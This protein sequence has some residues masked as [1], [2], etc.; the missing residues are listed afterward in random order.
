M[1]NSS[2]KQRYMTGTVYEN[3]IPATLKEKHEL[4]KIE[5]LRRVLKEELDKEA[6]QKIETILKELKSKIGVF[7]KIPVLKAAYENALS[8]ALSIFAKRSGGR[9]F[10]KAIGDFFTG[11]TPQDKLLKDITN[12]TKNLQ[13]MFSL[14]TRLSGEI[15]GSDA[16]LT[17]KEILQR[18]KA[19]ASPGE[20]EDKDPKASTEKI[21]SEI[22]ALIEGFSS[23]DDS[24][25][26]QIIDKLKLSK[27]T[28][29]QRLTSYQDIVNKSESSDQKEMY[30]KSIDDLNDLKTLIDKNLPEEE[31]ERDS[32]TPDEIRKMIEKSTSSKPIREKYQSLVEP[33]G[34]STIDGLRKNILDLM[35]KRSETADT[36]EK[37]SITG[38]I[39][40]LMSDFSKKL[41]SLSPDERKIEG[42]KIKEDSLRE[43]NDSISKVEAL[44]SDLNG[45]EFIK[46]LLKIPGISQKGKN[47]VLTFA[48]KVS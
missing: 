46:E 26:K 17:V 3:W 13:E 11:G 45:D 30:Q 47:I 9:G 12:F 8:E 23:A 16:S 1:A 14:V 37:R 28:I 41:E 7:D 15:S 34:D 18:S 10:F 44:D 24:K 21:K 5:D 39:S 6:V 32:Y 25:K 20:S 33:K 4:K 42:K 19:T 38:K 2:L 31:K 36:T 40:R 43:V 22:N 27:E 29:N 48:P 35:F